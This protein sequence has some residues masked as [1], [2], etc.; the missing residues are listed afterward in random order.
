M[1]NIKLNKPPRFLTHHMLLRPDCLA[2]FELPSYL[3]QQ[4]AN[5]LAVFISALPIEPEADEDDWPYETDSA[6]LVDGEEWDGD[7]DGETP[8]ANSLVESP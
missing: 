3:T 6:D 5:R 8:N 1:T 2:R 4:E 7:S